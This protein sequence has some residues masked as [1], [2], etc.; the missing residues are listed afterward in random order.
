LR[1]HPSLAGLCLGLV[2]SSG[3]WAQA[4]TLEIRPRIGDTLHLRY[5]QR[6]EATDGPSGT[7]A[8]TLM[9]LS[10]TIVVGRDKRGT[11]VVAV[12]DS[13]DMAPQSAEPARELLEGR[14]VHLTVAPDGATKLAKMDT[15]TVTPELKATLTE[16]PAMLPRKA[17]KVGRTWECDVQLPMPA[18]RGGKLKGTFRLDSVSRNGDLAYVSLHGTLKR[19]GSGSGVVDGAI[20]VDR[21]R[22][23]LTDSRATVYV[24]SAATRM[25]ITE[26]LRTTDR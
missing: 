3:A 21:R 7:M 13:V 17:I 15:K 16:M 19:D 9:V 23:W 25:T 18:G 6:T 26:W 20:V 2:V 24:T 4:V 1:V 11:D 22:G 5:D 10:R 12:T 8:S 14:P